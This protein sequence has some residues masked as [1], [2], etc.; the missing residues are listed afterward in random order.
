[1]KMTPSK[2]LERISK[3]CLYIV[4]VI[5]GKVVGFVDVKIKEGRAKVMG[6]AVE[7]KYRGRGVGSALLS[8]AV[9]VARERGITTVYLKVKK[10]NVN[11]IKFYEKHGFVFRKEVEKNGEG[12][13][14]MFRKFE[15]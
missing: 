15:T 10:S 14:I 6:L 11:A 8:K 9:E 13:Y 4:A 1:M 3:G 12:I 7:E 5:E 2:I